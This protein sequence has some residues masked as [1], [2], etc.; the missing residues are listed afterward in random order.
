MNKRQ[1]Y[2]TFRGLNI[3]VII[4]WNCD[5]LFILWASFIMF[6]RHRGQYWFSPLNNH[7]LIHYSWKIWPQ[8][9]I[10]RRTSPF[11]KDF[12]HKGLHAGALLFVR[13]SLEL[14]ISTLLGILS[15]PLPADVSPYLPVLSADSLSS[16]ISLGIISKKK[17]M[18]SL[19]ELNPY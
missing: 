5:H 9:R 1:I 11:L 14:T 18:A 17:F 13:S 4:L 7:V 6:P 3:K 16:K 12:S 2:H 19:F 15:P 8:G 10:L